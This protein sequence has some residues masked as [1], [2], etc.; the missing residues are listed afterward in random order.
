MTYPFLLA[1]HLGD[2]GLDLH[3]VDGGVSGVSVRGRRRRWWRQCQGQQRVLRGR[4]RAVRCGRGRQRCRGAGGRG[5]QFQS[6][7]SVFRGAGGFRATAPLLGRPRTQASAT[8]FH[9]LALQVVLTVHVRQ[10]SHFERLGNLEQRSDL[11][12]TNVDLS[13]VHEL[14]DGL[15]FGPLDVLEDHYRVLARVVEEESLEVGTAG[16]QDHL[17]RLDGVAVTGE[18]DIDEGLALEKLV[19]DVGKVGLV[20]V[21]S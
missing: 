14:D 2:A 11:F 19:E 13:L 1:D 15:E 21:P 9:G 7:R 18:C 3:V 17:V 20:V 6:L 8:L 5:H 10:S 12:L 4:G 16:G